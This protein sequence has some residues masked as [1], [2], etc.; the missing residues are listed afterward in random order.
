[1]KHSLCYSYNR[2]HDNLGR[3]FFDFGKLVLATTL[4]APSMIFDNTEK[5]EVD[6]GY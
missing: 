2:P 3:E 6:F 4:N 5:Y 1:M